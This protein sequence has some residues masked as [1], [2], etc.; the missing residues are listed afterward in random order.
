MSRS[1]VDR[2]RDIVHSADLVAHHA[3]N[4]GANELAAAAGPRDAALFRIAVVCEAAARLAPEVQAL[5]PQIP[6][7]KIR[8]MRNRIIHGYWQI[9]FAIVV[10]TIKNDLEPLKTAAQRLMTLV[11][12]NAQ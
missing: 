8:N 7:G 2:L 12:P 6:W 4:R 10:D 3:S 1:A 11:E 5:A 9:D